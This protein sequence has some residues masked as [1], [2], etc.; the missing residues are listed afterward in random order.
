M[1][2]TNLTIVVDAGA[3]DPYV[4]GEYA[5]AF[6]RGMQENPADRRHLMTSACCK[7]FAAN[8]MEYTAQ[9]GVSWS[10]HNFSADV[11]AQDLADSYLPPFQACVEKG[12]VSGLMWCDTHSL[13]PTDR[14]D[15][16]GC[17]GLPTSVVCRPPVIDGALSTAA[18]L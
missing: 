18:R 7:H 17:V 13:L 3:E 12:R 4:V 11:P 15:S 16:V 8:S 5:A 6:T 10:R 1:R 2:D 9:H 14:Y